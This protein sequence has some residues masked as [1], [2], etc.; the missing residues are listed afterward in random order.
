MVTL[1]TGKPQLNVRMGIQR[2]GGDTRWILVSTEPVSLGTGEQRRDCVLSTF[3][4]IT[5]LIEAQEAVRRSER[6]LREAERMAKLG[7]WTRDPGTGEIVWSEGL[8]RV[9]GRDAAA[10]PISKELVPDQFTPEGAERLKGALQKLEL[11]EAYDLDLELADGRGWLTMRGEVDRDSSGKIVRWRGT[12]Q[13]V[14][15]R[16]EAEQ[17][18]QAYAAELDDLYHRAPCGYHSLDGNGVFVRVN[19]VELAMLGYGRDELVGK[20]SFADLVSEEYQDRFWTNLALFKKSGRIDNLEYEMRRKDGSTLLVAVFAT[21]VRDEDGK[22]VRSRATVIDITERKRAELLKQRAEAEL[23]DSEQRYRQFVERNPAGVLRTRMDGGI[24]DCNAAFARMLGYETAAELKGRNMAEF[25]VDPEER[26]RLLKQLAET[27]R[28]LDYEVALKRRDGSPVWIAATIAMP[29]D[30]SR[31]D[32]LEGVILDITE[33]RQAEIALRASLAEKE[34]MLKEI[35]HRVKNNLQIVSSLLH[36]QQRAMPD[37]ASREAFRESENRVRSMA[38]IHESLYRTENFSQVDLG[39]YLRRVVEQVA[40]SY[41]RPNIVCDV[42]AAE[43]VLVTVQMALPCGLIV[44]E[45]V[46]N[47]LKYAFH[48]GAGAIAVEVVR[49]GGQLC[50][51]VADNGAGLPEAFQMETAGGLGMRLVQTLA[52]QLRATLSVERGPGAKFR[53]EFEDV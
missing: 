5:D 42:R 17:Q 4:D 6:G 3:T 26:K 33:R 20:M 12:V 9:M 21:A 7:S 41:R 14:T 39:E 43:G 51:T 1:R 44:N 18:I 50:L 36:L 37:E 46:S 19:E 13:D 49:E 24:E 10:A 31:G 30:D 28:A 27:K 40:A 35:H 38:G 22:F 25:W 34:V 15:E 29:A 23:R 32:A 16:K 52:G 11:G 48:G 45:L 2:P 8:Y 47:S 53:I